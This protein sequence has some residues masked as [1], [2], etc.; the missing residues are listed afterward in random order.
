MISQTALPPS[1]TSGP[2]PATSPSQ[3]RFAMRFLTSPLGAGRL[4]WSRGWIRPLSAIPP[5]WVSSFPRTFSRYPLL[6]SSNLD[7]LSNDPPVVNTPPR[8]PR[9]IRWLFFFELSSVR[10]RPLPQ[11]PAPSMHSGFFFSASL[12][13]PPTDDSGAC[14][15]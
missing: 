13:K 2:T 3:G 5:N 14:S 8:S 11:S 6:L 7:F 15:L 1:S 4:T 9:G 10:D 12:L